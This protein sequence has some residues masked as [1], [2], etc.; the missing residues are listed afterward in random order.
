MSGNR[1]L[2]N[3]LNIILIFVINYPSY[4]WSTEVLVSRYSRVVPIQTAI[5]SPLLLSS[6]IVKCKI[7]ILTPFVIRPLLINSLF[8]V[9][10]LAENLPSL[11]QNK[12]HVLYIHVDLQL[13]VQLILLFLSRDAKTYRLSNQKQRI[14]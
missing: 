4:C 12:T 9:I 1:N 14:N 3:N 6:K 5:K 8:L 7:G 11:Q 10:F 2:K 13:Y